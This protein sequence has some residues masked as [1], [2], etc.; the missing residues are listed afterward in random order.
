M[1]ASEQLSEVRTQI[2]DVHEVNNT[3]QRHDQTRQSFA[4]VQALGRNEAVITGLQKAMDEVVKAQDHLHSVSDR[5][6]AAVSQAIAGISQDVRRLQRE[7]SNVIHNAS[8][9]K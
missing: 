8:S 1:N 3:A 6:S 9:G 5:G 7:V 4:P 2:P